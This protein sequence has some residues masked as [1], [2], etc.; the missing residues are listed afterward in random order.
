MT[1]FS[2]FLIAGASVVH[3]Q[4]IYDSTVSP[5]PGNIPSVGAEAYSFTELGDEVTFAGTSR[6]LNTVKVTM[7]SWG[8]EAGHWFDATC[9]TTP[10]HTFSI[11]I[12][13]KI[14][15]PGLNNT[16]GSLIATR[17]QT[18]AIPYRPSS[19]NVHCTGG[20]WF[21]AAHGTCFN[22]LA[23]NIKFDYT[24]M[25]VVLPNTVVYGIS[26]NT[27]HYGPAPI[28]QLVPCY[29]S[30]AGCPYDSLNIGLGPVVNVGTKPFVNT[31]YQNAVYAVDYCDNGAAGVGFM[32][33]D[34]IINP[35]WTGYIPATKFNASNPPLTKD[36]CKNG[37]WQTRTTK[38]G[39]PFK[40]QGQCIDYV[41]NGDKDDKKDN[42]D[43][44]D[45]PDKGDKHDG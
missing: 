34:S 14:Y 1:A 29:T 37:G 2:L 4:T 40:N 20:R 10:G 30:S 28:G 25:N 26:Y 5:L 32:R 6:R 42:D 41:N 13:L 7:S 38:S 39:A 22:G 18:F 15:Q 23:A 3:G 44:D 17:T 8:C 9:V 45:R 21:D 31:I 33:L 16:A 35:C 19:D 43:E 24:S 12:T 36:D 27:S 11:Q